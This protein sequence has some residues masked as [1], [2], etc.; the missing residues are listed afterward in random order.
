LTSWKRSSPLPD[1]DLRLREQRHEEESMP[2]RKATKKDTSADSTPASVVSFSVAERLDGLRKK[3]KDGETRLDD[4]QRVFTE[5]TEELLE[6]VKSLDNVLDSLREDVRTLHRQ[7]RE[8]NAA[9]IS[10]TRCEE[11]RNETKSLVNQL[12]A[13][14]SDL[15]SFSVLSPDDF[16]YFRF[17]DLHRGSA[18]YV[19][20]S[21]SPY[22][23]YF[24]RS[25]RVV[26]LGCGR[27][28]FLDLCQSHGIGIY[29]V[30]SNEDMVL[31]CEGRG[32]N[33]VSADV[34]EHLE[35][36]PEKW[37][38]G[39][40]CSQVVEHLPLLKLQ[41][42]LRECSRVLKAGAQIVMVTINPTSVFALANN[43]FLDPTHVRPIPPGT[44][45]FLAEEAGF[46]NVAIEF[47]E[48]FGP[49]YSLLPVVVESETEWQ[50]ALRINF[51]RLN[52][53]VLGYQEYALI[54][55]K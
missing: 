27:G 39:I 15:Q 53:L 40:F 52:H 42:L 32:L 47:H 30:D 1:A 13:T 36:L 3:A 43:F 20:A 2:R 9:S 33:V 50:K 25:Q 6:R 28:E 29:G 17:E 41:R 31:H 4:L 46:R 18:D 11:Q 26:D 24:E 23:S 55:V 5:M 12:S 49:D 16:P 7:F 48:P 21:L 37:L 44:L 8:L 38:D 14:V 51:E 45:K 10:A 34:V 22:V 19:K 54:G 35:S